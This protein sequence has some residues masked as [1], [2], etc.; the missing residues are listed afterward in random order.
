MRD[1]AEGDLV[2]ASND[3]ESFVGIVIS[4]VNDVSKISGLDPGPGYE[5]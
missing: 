4:P 3:Y 1:I 2:K 5:V